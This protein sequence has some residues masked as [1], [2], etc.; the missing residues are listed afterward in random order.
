MKLRK[1]MLFFGLGTTGS[2]AGKILLKFSLFT[3]LLSIFAA[4]TIYAQSQI[5]GVPGRNGMDGRSGRNGLNGQEQIIRAGNQAIAYDLSGGEGDDGENAS[6]GENA[7]Q[8]QQPQPEFSIMGAQGGNGGN[9]GS[10]GN[11]GNGGNATI[12]FDEISQ[13]KNVLL[14]NNGGRPRRGGL[15]AQGGN[16]CTCQQSSWEVTYCI[17]ELRS[18]PIKDEKQPWQAIRQRTTLCSGIPFLGDNE[19][20]RPSHVGSDNNYRYRWHYIGVD[21]RDRHT[22]KNG[23][24]G[25]NGRNGSD[26]TP[27]AYGR[28][29]LVQGTTIP[30]EKLTHSEKVSTL[31]GKTIPFVKNNW[32]D[33]NGL[34]QLLASGSNASDAYALL[35]TKRRSLKVVWATE[36]SFTDLGDPEIESTIVASG[37]L[38]LTIPGTLESDVDI[39]KDITIV[40]IANGIHPNR[41]RQFQ[42]KG[43]YLFKDPS[44]IYLEDRGN[45]L[46]E[47]KQVKVTVSLYDR[48]GKQIGNKLKE[49]VYAIAP[50]VDPPQG[51]SIANN[52]YTLDFGDA[53]SPLLK[54]DKPM[55]YL[56]SIDQTTRAGATYNSGMQVKFVVGKI[57]TN[58][59][60]ERF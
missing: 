30:T 3:L 35:D 47:L 51:V 22:C 52:S 9:G 5:F 25:Q 18:Q 33:K 15:G 40:K 19:P 14:K 46:N 13:L 53:F 50:R 27:G 7:T 8:C 49:R 16:G 6:L 41:L 23:S 28:V 1:F 12:Y 45:L 10:G 24:Q 48:N 58:P 43:F 17:W 29:W 4:T 39:Q 54:P 20:S 2:I 57:N 34:G 59:E 55:A 32:L 31:S 11:G 44:K 21:R 38:N 42:F 56:I 36:K 37:M 26:G 60:V